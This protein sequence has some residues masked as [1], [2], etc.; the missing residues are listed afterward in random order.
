MSAS[1]LVFH[2]L[3][4]NAHDQRIENETEETREVVYE[5]GNEEDDDDEIENRAARRRAAF[6]QGSSGFG[7]QREFVIHL[8]GETAEGKTV[9]ADIVG[10]RPWF[11]LRLPEER[12]NESVESIKQ[13]MAANKIP[14]GAVNFKK[15]RYE[16]FFGFT[17]RTKFPFLYMDFPSQAMWRDARGLFLNDKSV[18]MTKVQLR[19]G[20]KPGQ[21][22]EVF[23]ANID[24]MLRFLHVQNLQ[25]CG[26]VVVEDGMEAVEEDNGVLTVTCDY[27]AVVPCK[28]PPRATAPFLVASWDIECYSLTGDFPIAK[29]NGNWKKVAKALMDGCAGGDCVVGIKVGEIL[30]DLVATNAAKLVKGNGPKNVRGFHTFLESPGFTGAI[31]DLNIKSE[32]AVVGFCKKYLAGY[33]EPCGDPVIQIGVSLTRDCKTLDRHLFVWPSCAPCDGITLHVFADEKAMIKGFFTWIVEK[34]PDIL[35]GYNVFGFDEKYLWERAEELGCVGESSDVHGLNRLKDIGSCVKLEEKFLSSSALGD[36]FMYIWSTQGRLQVDLYHYI[37]RNANLPSYKLDEVTKN[38]MSGK[39]KSFRIDGGDL[40]LEL[41]GAVKDIRPGRAICLLDG[42]GESV[43]DKLV[44]VEVVEGSGGGKVRV[45]CPSDPETVAE[46]ADAQKWVVVKDDVS[47]QDIFRLHRGSAEDRAIVGRYCIQD[48]DL[49]IELYKKLEV[50]NNAMSMANVCST[51]ISYIFVRGQGIKAESLIFKA[52]RERGVLIPVL[53]APKQ[54]GDGSEEDSY[55]G[56]IVLDPVPGFYHQSPI[57]VAD[58]ASLYPSTIE[59]ENISHDSL[60]WVK[61]YTYDGDLI[62]VVFGNDDFAECE[63]YGYTDIE[64]DIWRPDPADTRKHPVKIK[65]GRRVCRYAQPL[66]GS[67]STLP[68]IIRS[69]LAA[70]KAKRKEAEKETD[71]E[72]AALLD[73]EQLAYKLTGNSLYGQLGSGTFKVRLQHLAAS[74]T[75]YG[76]K[77]IMFAKA[78]IERFYTGDRD[79]RCDM[80]CEAK[81]VYGDS[82]TGDT[83]LLVADSPSSIPRFEA[84]EC[85][86]NYKG[87]GAWRGSKESQVPEE[88]LYVWTDKGWTQIKYIMRHKLAPE[89]KLYRI[90]TRGGYVDVTSDHSLLLPD[91]T[92][93]KPSEVGLGTKLLH[94]KYNCPP[95]WLDIVCNNKEEERYNI[96]RYKLQRAREWLRDMN[97]VEF[98]EK[99]TEIYHIQ[100]LNHPGPDVYVYDL[101]TENHHFAIGPGALVVH[102]TDSLF[103]EFNPRDVETG[104]RLTGR[105][106]RQACID[107]TAEAGHLVTQVLKPPHDFEFDKIF[108][109][110]LMF[111]KKRYA[112]LMFENNADEFVHKYMGIALKRRDNAPIVKTIFGGAM[113][114][115]LLEKDIVGATMLVKQLC[116]ELVAGKVSLNQLTITK[117]LRADYADPTRI[118]HKVLADRIAAR[119][120]GNAPA[121]GDRI[122]FVYIR[123]KPGQQDAKLQGDR[124]ETPGYV[125]EKGLSADYKFYIEHQIQNPVSQMFGILLESMPGFD[126][127]VLASSPDDSDKRIAWRETV[128]ADLL[129]REALRKCGSN[130]KRQFVSTFFGGASMVKT[131]ASN[132]IN[133]SSIVVKT[134]GPSA[135]VDASG[136]KHGVIVKKQVQSSISNY[137]LDS[138][139]VGSLTKKEKDA[140]RKKEKEAKDAKESKESAEQD[141]IKTTTKKRS[142]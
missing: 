15:E 134:H 30:L 18:P 95:E 118:A 37:R 22:P 23:E 103:V 40:Y 24:P 100:E 20:F 9:R 67:K 6:A 75:A 121:S 72:R 5:S 66:D 140:K 82:V 19:G 54:K 135:T 71:P 94:S 45:G 108:D 41:G 114:K 138:M 49:V 1:D 48:C 139:I 132:G 58:F 91:G 102:N 105:E 21:C 46:L 123:P 126:C 96:H 88:P 104:E 78:V 39:L 92:E 85:L 13:Y 70:R 44:I 133:S 32:D 29:S 111:S 124:I 34:N 27:R 60:V 137:I 52:C 57:G 107:L 25:P 10:F 99:D 11:Y 33:I 14:V 12:I 31:D 43:T 7:K 136:E 93:V 42:I 115:L 59:S 35:I 87:W 64:F 120:P 113:K 97:G 117:S 80:K 86:G 90:T 56:A 17:A 62:G 68:E 79:K 65:M 110:M 112:G 106:A 128:A 142:K 51:P 130:D 26:W 81:V 101:E 83:P 2:L 141:A 84:I 77:Q 73:A 16:S 109:P 69:L 129:F 116:D 47:P 127:R 38:Y 55:E 122:G 8:F 74:T 4:L 50:F 98:S 131:I 61:D 63:G 76:R 36:N 119:D 89:K 125:R 3:D 53:P 28:T